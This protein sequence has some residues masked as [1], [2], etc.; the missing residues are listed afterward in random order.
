MRLQ[1]DIDWAPPDVVLRGTLFDY[2]LV[3]WRSAGLDTGVGNQ[4]A[5]L[6]DMGIPLIKNGVL[7]KSAGW[8]VTVDLLN[9]EFVFLQIE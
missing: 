1:R 9:G 4:R 8:Q 5:V 2:A 3:L 7:V 6:R